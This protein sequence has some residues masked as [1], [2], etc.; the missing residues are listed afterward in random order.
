MNLKKTTLVYFSPTGGTKTVLV[1]IAKGVGLPVNHLDMTL[2][3]AREK[4]YVFGNDELVLI[5]FPVYG[6]RV[7]Q[8]QE[9]IF[10]LLKQAAPTDAKPGGDPAATSIV[11]VV[12][13]VVYGNREYD[14]ALLELTR[15][16]QEKNYTPVAAAAFIGEH[17][18]APELGA[19][20]PDSPDKELAKNF[21]E[22]L[23]NHLINNM[24]NH[25]RQSKLFDPSGIPG[26]TPYKER[27][28]KPPVVP[29]T[30][31]NCVQCLVCAKKC[32]MQAISQA[33]PTEISQER[34]ILCAACIKKCPAGAKR[35]TFKPLLERMAAISAANIQPKQP[36]LFLPEG[37]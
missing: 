12:P 31:Q 11:K 18:Y 7:P 26:N 8:I 25:P 22:R 15:L 29:E 36:A 16:C 19:K 6:G 2:P 9:T 27:A 37:A 13:V 35:I 3:A 28:P 33:N 10:P 30:D 32:P 20:R 24:D 5:G 21:G 14:D 34:C 17:S 4:Q 23:I 1:A